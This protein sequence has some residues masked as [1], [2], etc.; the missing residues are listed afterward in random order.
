VQIRIIGAADGA[1]SCRGELGLEEARRSWRETAA[2]VPAASDI[3]RGNLVGVKVI[4]PAGTIHGSAMIRY[5]A[6]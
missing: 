6:A 5:R 4:A 3:D 1:R 2:Q